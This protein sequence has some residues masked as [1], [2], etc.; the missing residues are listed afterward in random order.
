MEAQ[1]LKSFQ[2]IKDSEVKMKEQD[3]FLLQLQKDCVKKD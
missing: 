2:N 1:N 3:I